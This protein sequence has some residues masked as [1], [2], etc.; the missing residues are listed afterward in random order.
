MI[1]ASPALR[2]VSRMLP[3]PMVNIVS[4]NL[5]AAGGMGIQDVLVVPAGAGSTAEALERVHDVYHAA[6]DL[7]RARGASVL[8]G[9]EGGYGAPAL[10]SEQVIAL[11]T[12]A[13]KRQTARHR[14][15]WAS[16]WT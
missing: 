7:L 9:D 5:H 16:R 15:G 10:D 6:G 12:E 1:A 4:G 13:I 14:T 3:V 11:V 8:V 2:V